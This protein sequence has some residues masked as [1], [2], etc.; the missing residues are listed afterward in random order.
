MWHHR[1]ARGGERSVGQCWG[2]LGV[3]ESKVLQQEV[4]EKALEG[5]AQDRMQPQVP[6]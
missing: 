1:D 3:Q 2:V 5:W 6:V 4:P